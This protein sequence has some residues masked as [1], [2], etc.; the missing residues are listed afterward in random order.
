MH[1]APQPQEP[2]QRYPIHTVKID[3]TFIQGL[4]TDR[5]LAEMIV[6]M[7]RLMRLTVV[8]EGVETRDQLDWI[9]GRAIDQYQGFLCARALPAAA[10]EARFIDEPLAA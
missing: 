4:D 10:F 3:K 8:A 5:P 1:F 7:C 2:L 6:S 9:A